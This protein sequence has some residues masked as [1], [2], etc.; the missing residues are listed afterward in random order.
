LECALQL[1]IAKIN[2]TPYSGSSRSSKVIDLDTTKKL[3]TNACCDKQHAHGDLQP[4][5]RKTSQQ[6]QNND[7]YGVGG[8]GGTAI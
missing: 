7:F 2:K 4:F 8:E 1:K 6:R 5:S 3:I